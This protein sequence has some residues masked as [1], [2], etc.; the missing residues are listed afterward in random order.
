MSPIGNEPGV[1]TGHFALANDGL[2]ETS[3]KAARKSAKL[4]AD[5]FTY[6]YI[7]IHTHIYIYIYIHM[8]IYIRWNE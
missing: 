6:I 5:L 4:L 1:L 2:R 8:Y 7:Y 3:A